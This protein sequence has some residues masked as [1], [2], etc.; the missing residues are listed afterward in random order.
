MS[1]EIPGIISHT[2][3][4]TADFDR[5]T[6]FYDAVLKTLGCGRLMEVPG[7]VAYGKAFPEFWVQSPIDGKAATV[8]NGSHIGFSAPS[9]EAVHAFHEAAL[10]AG[11]TDDGAPRPREE[12]GAPYYGAFVR[13]LD[14]H[15]IEA[16]YWDM[17]LAK[18]QG[19]M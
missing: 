5:A 11:A 15:K 12:Y 3:L 18:E 10:K 13:D 6:A 19:M 14:G 2:S 4:G 9:K 16:A 8:G 1:D 17:A 7:A